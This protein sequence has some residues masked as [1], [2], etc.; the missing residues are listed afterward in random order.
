MT[1][2]YEVNRVNGK[3]YRRKWKYLGQNFLVLLTLEKD[4]FFVCE[5]L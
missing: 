4:V 5:N 3:V 2:N 1:G